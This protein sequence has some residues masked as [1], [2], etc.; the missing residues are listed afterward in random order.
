[1]SKPT[2]SLQDQ[3]PIT[4]DELLSILK[5]IRVDFKLYEH[6]PLYSVKESKF[7]QKLIF[8]VNSNGVHIKNL[9]LRD[10]KQRNYL[11]TCEQDKSIDLKI[12][13]EKI[14]SNRLSFGS[15]DRL[16]QNLGVFPGSVSPFCMLNGIKNNVNFYCDYDLKGYTKIFLHP[17][18]NDK[19]I[20]MN[21]DDLENFLKKY[22]ININ[23]IK[24]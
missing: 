1:M 21:L 7:Q 16:F 13:K 8:P 17:F 20:Y 18:T 11:I 12:L 23:W 22:H 24:L 2:L 6:K 14:K 3:L 15:P 4:S 10:K 19:T 9:Y 5:D